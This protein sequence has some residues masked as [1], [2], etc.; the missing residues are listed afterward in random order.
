MLVVLAVVSVTAACAI[1]IAVALSFSAWI[2]P[3]I[4]VGAFLVPAYNLELLGGRFHS[5]LWFALAWGAFPVLTGYVACTGTVRATTVVAAAWATVSLPRPAPA[6]DSRQARAPRRRERERRAGAGRRRTRGSHPGAARRGARG[7]APTA[8]RLGSPHRSCARCPAP[9]AFRRDRL[10]PRGVPRSRASPPHSFLWLALRRARKSAAATPEL[11]ADARAGIAAAVA[12]ETA[13]HTEEIRRTFA[14]E[15]ADTISQLAAEE[16]RL[17]EERRSTFA[18]RERRAGALLADT[19]AEVERRL[20]ERLQG[21]TDD[22]ERAQR[23]LE[24]QVAHLIQRQQQAF[25]E[26][27]THI[28]REAAELGSTSDE[29]RKA[30]IRLREELERAAATAVTE[31]LDELESH[32]MERRRSIE[33]V[34]DRLRAREAAIAEGIDSR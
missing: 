7:R 9:I 15:R 29:Q 14:R 27:E 32:T 3:L 28:A 10:Y 5:D 21:V 22:L 19:L 25:A 26:V 34:N 11:V 30:V 31:A 8:R 1:G 16:R 4:A 20:D 12:E 6:L 33:E 13:A 17:G 23:H 18:E 24:T 2:L